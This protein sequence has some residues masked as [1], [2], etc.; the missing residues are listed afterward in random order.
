MSDEL[1][2]LELGSFTTMTFKVHPSVSLQIM[3][4][5]YRKTTRYVVGTLLGRIEATSIEITNCY[6]VVL[7]EYSDDEDGKAEEVTLSFLLNLPD[8]CFVNLAWH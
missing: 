6:P 2:T 7:A 3:D 1:T 5:I 8:S 4:A